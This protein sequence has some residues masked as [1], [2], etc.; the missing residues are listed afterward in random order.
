MTHQTHNEIVL[1]GQ[2]N[3]VR[4]IVD[5]CHDN[6]NKEEWD[7]EL[8]NLSPSRFKISFKDEYIKTIALL[9]I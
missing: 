1:S 6:L 5:W 3:H 7:V 9:N 8:L 2:G 4:N